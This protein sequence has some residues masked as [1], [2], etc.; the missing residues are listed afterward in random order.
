MVT[1]HYQ[2]YPHI[3]DAVF[4][5]APP[6]SLAVMAMTCREWRQRCLGQFHHITDLRVLKAHL[7]LRADLRL[8]ALNHGYNAVILGKDELPLLAGCR[9]MD[10]TSSPSPGTCWSMPNLDTLRYRCHLGRVLNLPTRQIVCQGSFSPM[11]KA[12]PTV[13]R[14]VIHS[15][16]DDSGYGMPFCA[17]NGPN[18]SGLTGLQQLVL[19]FEDPPLALNNF[20][21]NASESGSDN[22]SNHGGESINDGVGNNSGESNDG[23]DSEDEFDWSPAADR[24]WMLSVIRATI[25]CALEL[26]A[27]VVLVG[28]E[29]WSRRSFNGLQLGIERVYV[30]EAE[31]L[32]HCC[33]ITLMTVNAYRSYIGEKEWA[34]ETDWNNPLTP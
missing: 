33:P 16:R 1:I 21:N 13:K 6:A 27:T 31:V 32:A 10:I 4:A 29:M 24:K 17:V 20:A 9:V 15:R 19:I 5:Y 22:G 34:V 11:T 25:Q 12:N 30:G 7:V 23:S 14:L 2:Y 26:H 28:T 18:L 3:I 8:P